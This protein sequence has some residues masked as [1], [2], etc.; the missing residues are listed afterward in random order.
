MYEDWKWGHRALIIHR[1]YERIHGKS[2]GLYKLLEL[3][4]LLRLLLQVPVII[5]EQ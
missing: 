1:W 2:S 4:S 3:I 5:D